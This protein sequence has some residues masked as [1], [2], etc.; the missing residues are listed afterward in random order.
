M[1][2]AA[3]WTCGQCGH[4][5]A[6]SLP[7]CGTCRK[8][9]GL[10]VTQKDI[11]TDA[12]GVKLPGPGDRMNK[13]ERDYSFRLEAMRQAGNIN[14]WK[15]QGVR[16]LWGVDPK[17]GRAMYYK[18]DFL[19]FMPSTGS[20]VES[21]VKLI[22][23]KGPQIWDRDKVRFRGCRAEYPEFDFELWQREKG[24]WRKLE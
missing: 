6:E 21:R 15:F 9:R 18:P 12:T 2:V 17:T 5:N 13:T 3:Y 7:V 8:P 24:E 22:E 10:T 16:L 23:V 4:G 14:R 19:V 20:I 1:G 11:I